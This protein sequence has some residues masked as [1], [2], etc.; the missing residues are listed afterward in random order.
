MM[1]IRPS[2]PTSVPSDLHNSN[3]SPTEKKRIPFLHWLLSLSVELPTSASAVQLVVP[4][5]SGR[6]RQRSIG[7]STRPLDCRACVGKRGKCSRGRG[8]VIREQLGHE[9]LDRHL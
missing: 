4:Q 1:S 8:G 7:R 3:P 6:P 9:S 5:E 2:V